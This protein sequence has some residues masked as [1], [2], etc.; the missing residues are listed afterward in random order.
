MVDLKQAV[1]SVEF[2]S[3]KKLLASFIYLVPAACL[4]EWL[5]LVQAGK[6]LTLEK[7]DA[8]IVVILK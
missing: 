1:P 4:A 6:E 3:H 2:H 7:A 5:L 8:Q